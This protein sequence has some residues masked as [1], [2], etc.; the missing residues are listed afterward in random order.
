MVSSHKCITS[1]PKWSSTYEIDAFGNGSRM[2]RFYFFP[3]EY[4]R[5]ASLFYHCLVFR[6]R[7]TE[8]SGRFVGT[9][10]GSMQTTST[11]QQ[12]TLQVE[13]ALL[14]MLPYGRTSASKPCSPRNDSLLLGVRTWRWGLSKDR[15]VSSWSVPDRRSVVHLSVH[16]PTPSP[17]V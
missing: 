6:A 10:L 12:S 8:R 2:Q 13:S 7:H 3:R 1:N 17:V 9:S 11:A 16:I 5:D 15:H 4:S 14:T